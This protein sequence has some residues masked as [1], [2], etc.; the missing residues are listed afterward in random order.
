MTNA[1]P[2]DVMA[3]LHLFGLARDRLRAA[4]AGRLGVGL[5]DIDA[6]EYLEHYAAMTQRE[7]GARLLLTSGAV[8]LL[9]DRLERMGLVT[10]R[11][12]PDDRRLTLV[13]LVPDSELPTLPE[14]EA[15]HQHL[16][17]AASRLNPAARRA[18]VDLLSSLAEHAE[19]A[20][21]K[22]RGRTEP[23]RRPG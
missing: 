4:M 1:T 18:I 22:M 14:M 9:V 17:G 23:R 21:E 16:K 11:V 3:Q 6:L 10:R 13:E 12:H 19:E 20:S 5:T 8:T 7:L 2:D 15:F